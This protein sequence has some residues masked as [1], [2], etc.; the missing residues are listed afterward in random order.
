MIHS[1]IGIGTICM[2]LFMGFGLATANSSRTEKESNIYSFLSAF[3]IIS[4]V[5][6]FVIA[7]FL[8]F[9]YNAT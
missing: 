9:F 3:F 4:A 1:L 5:I 6:L 2:V 8:Y 7:A